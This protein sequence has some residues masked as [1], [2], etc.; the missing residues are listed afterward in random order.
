MNKKEKKKII[1]LIISLILLDQILKI[2]IGIKNGIL[3][4][5]AKDNISYILLSIIAII[6]LS[7]YILNNNSF[8]KLN[9]RIIISFALAGAVSN[10]IDRI[11][12]G[13]VITYIEIPGFMAINLSYIY[14]AIT[15]L[16]MAVILTKY[17]FDR[18]EER[19]ALKNGNNSNRK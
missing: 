13:K 16:G 5:D 1:I 17:T 19:K 7:R 15:W 8:I 3:P 18:I 11:W 12:F 9:S 10:M 4:N 2:T 6:V 14:I